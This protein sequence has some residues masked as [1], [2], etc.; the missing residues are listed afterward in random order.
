MNS[1]ATLFV[2]QFKI[3]Q[4]RSQQ[5]GEQVGHYHRHIADDDAVNEPKQKNEN[6]PNDR[7]FAEPL[8]Q[9]L[10]TC[11]KNAMVVQEPAA[12]PRICISFI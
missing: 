4:R 11:G 2:A 6:M 10:I 5:K 9:V 3:K 12:N 8:F 1:N 7:S